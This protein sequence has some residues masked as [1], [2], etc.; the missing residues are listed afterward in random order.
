MVNRFGTPGCRPAS[1]RSPTT[2]RQAGRPIPI[3]CSS[4]S[5]TYRGYRPTARRPL[6]TPAAACSD[7]A[8]RIRPVT[9]LRPS[10]GPATHPQPANRAAAPRR[11]RMASSG[12]PARPDQREQVKRS[13]RWRPAGQRAGRWPA[14]PPIRWA[15]RAAPSSR[16]RS[17]TSWGR[18]RAGPARKEAPTAR[19]SR[20]RGRGARPG[21]GWR[22]PACRASGTRTP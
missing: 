11:G 18:R 13:R 8:A 4:S 20:R 19:R 5:T 10:P 21:C 7:A 9:V 6:A 17:C 15:T 14:C 3:P 2:L 16:S 22:S 12:A 1:R